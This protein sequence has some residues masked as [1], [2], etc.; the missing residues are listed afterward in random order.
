MYA[1]C[2]EF[3]Y[4]ALRPVCP[5]PTHQSRNELVSFRFLGRGLSRELSLAR[6]GL[7]SCR[8]FRS[9][10]RELTHPPSFLRGLRSWGESRTIHCQ[11]LYDWYCIW[12]NQ[13]LHRAERAVSHPP[14]VSLPQRRIMGDARSLV[15]FTA[16]ITTPTSH[17]R[18]L[19][20]QGCII[21]IPRYIIIVLSSL[22]L[23]SRHF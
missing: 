16:H 18:E 14:A 3:A 15:G 8:D 10:L 22:K 20:T 17:H 4:S 6:L 19:G 12:P 5:V 9:F 7:R 13:W 1:P 23:V 2:A 21:S 11:A